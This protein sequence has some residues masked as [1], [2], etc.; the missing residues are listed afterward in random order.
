MMPGVETPLLPQ[1]FASRTPHLVSATST[2]SNPPSVPTSIPTSVVPTSIVDATWNNL[3][4]RLR[5][6][7]LDVDTN[8]FFPIGL[9]GDAIDQTNLAKKVCR[10]CAVQPQCLE[11]A[12][13][14]NQDYGVWGGCTEDERR[15]IRRSRR[16]AARRAAQA[17]AS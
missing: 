11:F 5:S 16:A 1:E 6:A 17:R 2:A 4:W 14:T 12:L 15:A 10:D 7:C 13:R 3:E 9:T 8:L